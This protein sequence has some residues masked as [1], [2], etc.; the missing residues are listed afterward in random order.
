MFIR[1][2]KKLFISF[3]SVDNFVLVNEILYEL[4]L[5]LYVNVGS[6]SLEFNVDIIDVLV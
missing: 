3:V 2:T 1:T 6:E 5:I 4:C